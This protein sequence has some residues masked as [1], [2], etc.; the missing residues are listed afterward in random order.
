VSEPDAGDHLPVV[1]D[2]RDDDRDAVRQ[3]CFET[4][5]MGQPIAWQ[6]ADRPSFAHLFCDW[7]LDR[8]PRFASVVELDG[9]VVGYRL[10][11]PD[12]D[13]PSL[14]AHER[15]YATRH[16]LGRGLIVRPGTA[17]FLW[18]GARDLATDR[19][20]LQPPVDHERFPADLHID[21]LPTARGIGVGR[22]M[23]TEW[24]DRLRADGVPGVHL[25]TWGENAP[26]LAFFTS[27][28]FE[29]AGDPGRSP[30][31]RQRDGSRCTVQWMTRSL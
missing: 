1:R 27:L 29:R 30:G 13:D 23:V 17:G 12:V 24:L 11:C 2:Y 18:R 16:V 22:R 19:S 14:A 20:V 3:V 7:Y 31:F 8:Y 6:Y 10:G 4:G 21:F 28:G 9:A 25:G 5:Y 26:A 15:A